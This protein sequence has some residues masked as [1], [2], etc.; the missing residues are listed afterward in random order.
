MP[1]VDQDLPW[2][3]PGSPLVRGSAQCSQR[4][5]SLGV[6]HV[7]GVLV[8]E[9]LGGRWW[10]NPGAYPRGTS[11]TA[12]LEARG[13]VGALLAG[14]LC[15]FGRSRTWLLCWGVSEEPPW[16]RRLPVGQLREPRGERT[17]AAGAAARPGP[18]EAATQPRARGGRLLTLECSVTFTFG[19]SRPCHH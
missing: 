10:L 12:W 1:C 16:E 13:A 5:S 4:G 8:L 17:K 3:A 6:S 7:S 19:R 15:G 18:W 2:P 9:S 11:P 14:A